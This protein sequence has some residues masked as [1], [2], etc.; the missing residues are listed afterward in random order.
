VQTAEPSGTTNTASLTTGQPVAARDAS[1]DA[2]AVALT[3]SARQVQASPE[4]TTTVPATQPQPKSLPPNS[5]WFQGTEEQRV[6]FGRLLQSNQAPTLSV[7]Q[8]TN[9]S[10]LTRQE[11]QGK[12]VVLT[13]WSTWSKP[14]LK[15]IDFNNKLHR[16]FRDQEVV[17]IGVCN[18]D[19][20]QDLS[21]V[22]KSKSISYPVAIDDEGNK[23]LAAYEVQ[24]LPT[25]FVIDRS[26]KLR[27]A[28]I[29]RSYLDEALEF[30]LS[31][32]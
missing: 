29:K 18:T 16:H 20:S 8:W 25:Y 27:F 2:S 21:Q 23:S 10:P 22:V 14:C 4:A 19:G 26:G 17:L 31:E 7:N 5:S 30:L 12:I 15:A 28:D 11:T 24:A 6:R 9:S 32:K 13:F 1:I 3:N